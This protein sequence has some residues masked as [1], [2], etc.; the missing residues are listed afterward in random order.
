MLPLYG[1]ESPKSHWQK[2]LPRVPLEKRD[3]LK[4]ASS[5]CLDPLLHT[6][7]VRKHSTNSGI[8]YILTRLKVG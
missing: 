2:S 8:M 3:F 6:S 1:G 4:R 7:H 5:S